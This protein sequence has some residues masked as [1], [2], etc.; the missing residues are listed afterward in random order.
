MDN[1][2][3]APL[4]P[5]QTKGI[6]KDLLHSITAEDEED[7]EDMF[8]IAKDR[9]LDIN[10]W[11]EHST[12]PSAVFQLTDS[13]GKE[14]SRKAHMGDYLKIDIPGPGPKT[15]DGYDWVKIEELVYDDYPDEHIESIGMR[16]RPVASP[17]SP[18]EDTAHFFDEN[19]TSTF[20][21]E[22]RNKKLIAAYHGRNEVTNNE[23]E[24]TVDNIRNTVVGLHAKLGFSDAQWDGLISGFIK[25]DDE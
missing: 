18:S 1:L 19:A 6:K 3:H 23:T 10:N 22:R 13:H 11:K 21:I 24:T 5:E 2:K 9:L 17:V 20:I 25:F 15:G 4:V 7:A 12:K 8:L 14:V 16:V